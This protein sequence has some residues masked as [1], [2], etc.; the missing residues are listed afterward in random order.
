M[1]KGFTFSNLLS[2]GRWILMNTQCKKSDG[3]TE[4]WFFYLT[5][6]IGLRLR[7]SVTKI[8]ASS[9]RATTTCTCNASSSRQVALAEC[10]IYKVLSNKSRKKPVLGSRCG[11]DAGRG[12]FAI[13]WPAPSVVT[14]HSQI[15]TNSLASYIQIKFLF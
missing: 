8:G 5:H 4:L 7:L 9:M 6:T 3:T 11:E 13:L 14:Y 15:D 1:E 2:H 10:L 12:L